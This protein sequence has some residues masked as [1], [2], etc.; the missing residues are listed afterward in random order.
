MV[1]LNDVPPPWCSKLFFFRHS[2]GRSKQRIYASRRSCGDTNVDD[3]SGYRRS[4]DVTAFNGPIAGENSDD[5]IIDCSTPTNQSA[6]T[7]ADMTSL[8][9]LFVNIQ[10]LLNMAIERSR[11]RERQI[12][13]EKGSVY[14]EFGLNLNHTRFTMSATAQRWEERLMRGGK[15]KVGWVRIMGK[16]GEERRKAR[17]IAH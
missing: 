17:M 10:G 5:V 2:C 1:R 7:C 4:G 11:D 3:D 13:Y 15:W 8:E 14:S 12:S 9:T 16:G 6:R